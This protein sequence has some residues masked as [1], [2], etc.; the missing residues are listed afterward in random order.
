M[1]FR[2]AGFQEKIGALASAASDQFDEPAVSA[3]AGYREGRGGDIG[4][5][6]SRSRGGWLPKIRG[7]RH[8]SPT[9]ERDPD[10][11]AAFGGKL[12]SPRGCHREAGDF[13]NHAAKTSVPQAF[14]E[15]GE[16]GGFVAGIDIDHAIGI[17]ASLGQRRREEIRAGHAPQHRSLDPGEDAGGEQR[18]GGCVDHAG[19][20]A[21]N[22]MQGTKR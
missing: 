7:L 22:F 1:T 18:G 11:A 9:P 13:G 20:S 6:P 10:R 14:L 19:R 17:E 2:I 15:T 21:R 8:S 3:D 12:Q 4:D 5:T 16:D